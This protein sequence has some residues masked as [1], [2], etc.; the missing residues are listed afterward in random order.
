MTTESHRTPG[1]LRKYALATSCATFALIVAGGIV[2]TRGAGLSVPDW[3][4]SYGTLM[5]ERW[6]AIPN[7][8]AE[9]SHRMIA[10]AVALMMTGLAFCVQRYEP[11]SWVRKLAWW[12]LAAVIAQALLGGATVLILGE[13]RSAVRVFH[14]FVAQSF[15][16]L[17][18][19]LSAAM[20]PW[21]LTRE[22]GGVSGARGGGSGSGMPRVAAAVAGVLF[23]QLLLGALM[24]HTES[25]TALVDFPTSVGDRWLP[26]TDAAGL[27]A[28]N[29][30]RF[31][32]HEF[33]DVTIAQTWF[34]FA[35]RA[36]AI[37]VVLAVIA[38]FVYTIRTH[39]AEPLLIMPAIWLIGLAAAQIAL[40]T[41]TVL[42]LRNVWITTAHVA[43]GVLTLAT[44]FLL[45]VRAFRLVG[46]SHGAVAAR[47]EA[48]HL[49]GATA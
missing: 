45:A 9:H 23:L 37:A 18:I 40:G 14:A 29:A 12:A 13:I 3:P 31:E 19:L 41:M 5:P 28:L 2:T 43:V 38:L 16:L 7:I 4:L 32:Q 21:W 15:F 34:N 20:S 48:A 25:G 17:T 35:H 26:P 46:T 10:G 11:R 8:A 44:G 30:E 22:R 39:A 33:E 1:W 49:A 24:R 36:W 42:T 27:A 47:V 6:Y